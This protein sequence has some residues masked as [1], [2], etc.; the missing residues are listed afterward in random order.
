MASNTGFY[1]YYIDSRK[2][3][4]GTDSSFNYIISL[5]DDHKFTHVCILN[6]LIPKSYYLIQAGYNT[7][8]L[9]EDTT[10]VTIT[11]PP[12]NYLKGVFQAV[13]GGLLSTAS[14]N[15]WVYT[16]TYPTG[17][18][19]DT[20][21]FTYIVTGN[22]SQ[23]A[24]I[25]GPDLFEPF[26]F[27]QNSINTFI[28]DSIT[29]TAVI[30]LV[31]EDRLIIHSSLVNNPNEDNILIS[32]NAATNVPFSSVSYVTFA[33]DYRSHRLMSNTVKTASFQ[34]TNESNQILDLNGLNMNFTLAFYCQD[35]ILDIIRQYLKVQLLKIK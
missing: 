2:R 24:L 35:D 13:I 20:G 30:K 23:P 32:I 22:T 28:G 33:P 29:S 7:F 31:S 10:T 18:N 34:L 11:V 19:P 21:K 16:I 15:G 1:Y 4:S 6:A 26:G 3:T 5:P 8:Q 12:G 9:R 25:F 14:P 27:F 17:N